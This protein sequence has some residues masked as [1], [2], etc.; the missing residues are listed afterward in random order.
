[1]AYGC[2]PATDEL[3]VFIIFIEYFFDSQIVQHELKMTQAQAMSWHKDSQ[4]LCLDSIEIEPKT[5]SKAVKKKL[6]K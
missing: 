5:C 1:M 6:T 3:E 4:L 2:Y